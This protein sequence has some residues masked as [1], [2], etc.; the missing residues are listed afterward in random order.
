MS[1]LYLVRVIEKATGEKR[2]EK[3]R[4]EA[5][6]EQLTAEFSPVACPFLANYRKLQLCSYCHELILRVKEESRTSLHMLP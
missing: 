6:K 4:A 2:D 5:E 1:V 3:K